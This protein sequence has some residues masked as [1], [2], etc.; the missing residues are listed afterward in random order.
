MKTL[1]RFFQ[2]AWA[3]GGYILWWG[4]LRAHL[5]KPAMPPAQ[6]L[7]RMLESLGTTFVKLGQ[8]LSL[9]QDMLP[10]EY[11]EALQDLQD[12][13]RPFPSQQ[14][15][16]SIE[17]AL[18]QP[19]AQLFREFD[20][21]P[22]AAASIAQVHRAVLPDGRRVIV[23][24]RRPH[25]REQV[26]Q[27]LF[28]LKMVLRVVLALVPR[29]KYYNL[30]ENVQESGNSLEKE[31]DFRQEMRNIQRFRAAFEGSRTVYI[32]AAIEALCSESVMVQEMSN[33]QPMTPEVLRERGPQLARNFFDA[34]LYQLFVMGC[35]HGDPH[36]GNLFIM[37]DGR[38]CFH[39][40]GLVGLIDANTRR[41][42]AGFFLAF[43]NQDSDWL[44]DAYLDLGL[45]GGEVDRAEV[46]RGLEELM[47][48]F[49][50]LPLK[51]WSIATAMI[52]AVR[53]GW[54]LRLRLPHHLL[55]MMRA[56]FLVEATVRRLDPE[57]NLIEYLQQ[58]GPDYL[59]QTLA[60]QGH[61]AGL[62]RLKFETAMLGQDLPHAMARWLRNARQR[63][64]EIPL[65]HHGLVSFEKHIDRSSN[66]VSLAL[67]ALGLYIASS[68]LAQSGLQP[69][70]AGM[71]LVAVT[72]YGL[73]LWVSFR[74]LRGIAASG[75]V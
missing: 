53:M 54:G 42:L 52:G 12:K 34:Y 36:P 10:P 31:M 32:P 71:P 30:L 66:R 58:H 63:G 50:G 37:D 17:Q 65:H 41:H 47:Q 13:V 35:V 46:T 44:L 21:Q 67:V 16:D 38:I 11:V 8:G 57:F 70:L 40:F 39:D 72:G 14:V 61:G 74:L 15:R 6:R 19:V 51:D 73:A 49:A 5:I 24:V 3:I 4:V 64:I 1:R 68:L 55:V 59:K 29:L 2:I 56:L 48:T 62:A 20:D 28:L 33:G 26:R 69:Q 9:R 43:I 22:L 7:A 23:K 18:G 25:L 60:A 45:L 75:K 27:D